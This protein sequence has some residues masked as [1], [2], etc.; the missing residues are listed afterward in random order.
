[1][2]RYFNVL[3]GGSK[4]Q[5]KNS[6]YRLKHLNNTLYPLSLFDNYVKLYPVTLEYSFFSSA[7]GAFTKIVQMLG[8]NKSQ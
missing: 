1:M 2:D 8:H 7:P 3:G 6:Q 5:Q 4:N